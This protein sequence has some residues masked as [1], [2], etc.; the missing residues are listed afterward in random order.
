MLLFVFVCAQRCSTMS[1]YKRLGYAGRYMARAGSA[2]YSPAQRARFRRKARNVAAGGY[3]MGLRKRWTPRANAATRA[4]RVTNSNSG[5]N[6]EELKYL[7]I[8]STTYACGT[9]GLVTLINGIAAGN[10]AITRE[11]RQCWWK[12]V[13][14]QGSIGAADATTKAC[15]ADVYVIFD[16]QPGAAVPAV[17]DILVQAM[18]GSPM[19]LDYRERFVTLAHQTFVIGGLTADATALTPTIHSVQINKS[20]NMRTTFKGDANAIGDIATG[21]IYLLTVG[22][23]ADASGALLRASI[24]FRFAEK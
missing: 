6:R 21:A 20:L 3:T 19:N 11:G 18:A 17:T 12:S 2:F 1:M 14:V 24:R 10:T 7:D 22:D 9:T 5:P 15:R 8:N 13:A 23:Q 16:K 4:F